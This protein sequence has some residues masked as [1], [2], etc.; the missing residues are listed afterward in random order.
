MLSGVIAREWFFAGVVW[1]E[2]QKED[3]E[4]GD[5][6]CAPKGLLIVVVEVVSKVFEFG[7]E[8]GGLPRTRFSKSEV[9]VAMLGDRGSPIGPDDMRSV[10]GDRKPLGCEVDASSRSLRVCSSSILEDS[11]FTKSINSLNCWRLSSGPRLKLH[12]KGS[13]S[14]ARNS[15]SAILPTSL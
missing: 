12:T 7:V 3:A 1:F 4:I 10:V 8:V 14:V 5:P 6:G 2:D 15:V 9:D 13:T 11:C